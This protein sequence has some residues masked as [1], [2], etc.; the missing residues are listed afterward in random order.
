M[1]KTNLSV[2]RTFGKFERKLPLFQVNEDTRIAYVDLLADNE[3]LNYFATKIAD[4]IAIDS[5]ITERHH[6][7]LLTA[8]NKGTALAHLVGA[9]LR[10]YTQIN[11]C[12]VIVARKEKKPFYGECAE[13]E[14]KSITNERVE[15]LYITESDVQKL[16]GNK[17]YIID[18]VFTT[19]A[20]IEALR[21]LA[22]KCGAST[23]DNEVY[24]ALWER[25]FWAE[26]PYN[27]YNVDTLDLYHNY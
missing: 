21:E 14:K 18:D 7:V 4:E 9:K 8:A 12:D 24:V 1:V 3:L 27:F 17:V 5:W 10:G 13:T 26:K 22:N 6:A 11:Q 15:K 25:E 19:G 20:S 23:Q 2:T 16:K